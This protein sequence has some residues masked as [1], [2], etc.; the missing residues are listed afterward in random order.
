MVFF[1]LVNEE[2]VTFCTGSTSGQ[3]HGCPISPEH[4]WS[5][6][7]ERVQSRRIGWAARGREQR[8]AGFRGVSISLICKVS[9][10]RSIRECEGR[11]PHIDTVAMLKKSRVYATYS[12]LHGDACTTDTEVAGAWYQF[13]S[14]LPKIVSNCRHQGHS[15]QYCLKLE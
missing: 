9:C 10:L 11:Q 13:T 4:W 14:F 7:F 3:Q 2:E 5:F 6:P 8:Y 15:S 1:L 12:R